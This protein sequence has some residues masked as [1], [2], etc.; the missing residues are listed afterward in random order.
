MAKVESFNPYPHITSY[1]N[2]KLLNFLRGG[3]TDKILPKHFTYFKVRKSNYL[4]D[5]HPQINQPIYA[6]THL[7]NL[8]LADCSTFAR[9]KREKY[10]LLVDKCCRHSESPNLLSQKYKAIIDKQEIRSFQISTKY[11]NF[12]IVDRQTK[13]QFKLSNPQECSKQ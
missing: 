3:G 10:A 5:H 9:L 4:F 2:K 11:V 7:D 12:E 13:L 8:A 6:S 1:G